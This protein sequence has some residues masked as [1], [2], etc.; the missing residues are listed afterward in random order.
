MTLPFIDTHLHVGRLY[1]GE[2]GIIK[3]A[4]LLPF[5]DRAG[6]ERAALMPIESPEE[7]HFYVTTEEIL[8]VCRSHPDRLVPFCNV[9]P[10][11][12]GGDN[13]PQIRARLTEYRDR[14]CK[15]YGEA[16]SGL[17]IDDVRLQRIYAAC[18]DLG[19]PVVYHIDADRNV[20]GVG[21]P[22]LERMLKQFPQT[23]FVGHGQHFW[24]EIS[25]DVTPAQFSAYPKGPVA[26]GGAV[27]RLMS[28]YPNLYADL[29][30]G[31]GLNALTRDPD[32]GFASRFLE[33]FQDKLFFATDSCVAGHFDAVP[34]IAD[35][36]MRERQAGRLGS[37]AFEK[38]AHGNAV[39]VFGL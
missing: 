13:T 33:R 34:G 2:Q 28:A 23:I 1:V 39:R 21:M 36:L 27:P 16:M 8:A 9:D 18:G 15:G 24:A 26:K 14:G 22:G 32:P 30:A 6:I 17:A 20:D 29:S 11:I 10:R 37:G 12:G 7:A 31:S 38:I 5:M 4:S 35:F 3:P 19:L 25:G